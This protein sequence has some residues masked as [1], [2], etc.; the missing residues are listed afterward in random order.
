MAGLMLPSEFY[1]LAVLGSRNGDN[2]AST[3]D[4]FDFGRQAF[5]PLLT[6]GAAIAAGSL[7]AL[8]TSH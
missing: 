1:R 6:F 7:A 3:Q 8:A 2:L 5:H 4:L